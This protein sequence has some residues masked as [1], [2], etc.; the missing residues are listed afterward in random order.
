MTGKSQTPNCTPPPRPPPRPSKTGRK[1]DGEPPRV[2]LGL[3]GAKNECLRFPILLPIASGLW[4]FPFVT[5]ATSPE[6]LLQR[7]FLGVGS[8]ANSTKWARTEARFLWRTGEI[9]EG[10][11]D[12]GKG[13]RDMHPHGK[14]DRLAAESPLPLL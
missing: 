3:L 2:K 5:L 14:D 4:V 12:K 9:P 13:D 6:I 11:E 10:R 1:T 7:S 8:P